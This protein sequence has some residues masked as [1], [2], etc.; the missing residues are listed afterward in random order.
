PQDRARGE[1]LAG[2]GFADKAELLGAERQRHA[3]HG[4][5]DAVRGGKADRQALDLDQHQRCFGSSTSRSPSPSRL[6]PSEATKIATPGIIGTHHC[7]R[8]KR[9][10]VAIIEP[11]S[12]D[13]GCAPM[14]R[15]PSAAAVRMIELMSSVTR[16]IRLPRHK[17]AMC[18]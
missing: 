17:G 11:H 2:T 15:K 1:R 3:A 8:M 14:P 16:T 12:G 18:R 9:R 7:S 4:L 5:A 6:K 10:A 13:G